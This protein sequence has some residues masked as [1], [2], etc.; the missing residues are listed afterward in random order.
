MS[1]CFLQTVANSSMFLCSKAEDTPCRLKDNLIMAY[2]LM[3]KRDPLASRRIRERKELILTG[4]RLLLVA[5]AF[6]LNIEHPYKPLVA[7][8]KNLKISE[9]IQ[10]MLGSLG[11]NTEQALPSS[12]SGKSKPKPLAGEGKSNSAESCISSDSVI[13]QDSS[14]IS[15][16]NATALPKSATAECN[17][18]QSS[19]EESYQNIDI[20]MAPGSAESCISSGSVVVLDLRDPIYMCWRELRFCNCQKQPET[21][22]S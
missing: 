11:M 21:A 15:L 7:A 16:A 13:R 2:K 9:A 18:K 6:D 3:Y 22:M 5:V 12:F 20:T 4:E 10:H 1:C 8:M 19:V 14:N 17:Q